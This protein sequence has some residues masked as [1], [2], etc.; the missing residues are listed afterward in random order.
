MRKQG[1]IDDITMASLDGPLGAATVDEWSAG[2]QVIPGMANWEQFILNAWSG[3][4]ES[5]VGLGGVTSAR[6]AADGTA[7]ISCG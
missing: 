5:P 7:P 6:Y 1:R 2:C 4:G 3:E